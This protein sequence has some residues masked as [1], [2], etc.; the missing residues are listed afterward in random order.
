MLFRSLLNRR[1][2]GRNEKCG[3]KYTQEVKDKIALKATGRKHTEEAK[4][5]ISASCRGRVMSPEERE[6]RRQ[7]ALK[8]ETR[9]KHAASGAKTHLSFTDESRQKMSE[10]GRS[11]WD[12]MTPE[13]LAEH[14]RKRKEGQER[15]RLLRLQKSQEQL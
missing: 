1:R 13:Q 2:P 6:M 15:A 8:P 4:A 10:G 5:K 14:N 11:Y 7:A 3:G 12:N 9:A